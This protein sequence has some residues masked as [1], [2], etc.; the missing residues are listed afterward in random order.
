MVNHVIV[1]KAEKFCREYGINE[2]P[3]KIVDICQKLGLSVFEEQLPKNVSGLILVQNDDFKNYGTG[4]LI[5][6]NANDSAQ[7]RRFTIAH[8]LAHYMLHRNGDELYAHRDANNPAN[9]EEYEANEFASNILMPR[10]LVKQA[11]D[12]AGVLWN[13]APD[14]MKITHIANRFVVSTSAAAVRLSQLGYVL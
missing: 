5:V 6:I 9:R 10:E 8:E 1:E 14:S 11:I 13:D 12:E 2:Y 7:R 3:V 4:K